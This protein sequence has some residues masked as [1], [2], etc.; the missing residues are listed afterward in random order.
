MA[1][2]EGR[3][4]TG[5]LGGYYGEI[6]LFSFTFCVIY[7]MPCFFLVPKPLIPFS[8]CLSVLLSKVIHEGLLIFI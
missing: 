6:T 5:F 2:S 3:E 4:E 1:F 7:H 8:S